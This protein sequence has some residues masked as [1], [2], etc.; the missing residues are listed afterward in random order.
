MV[1]MKCFIG[2]LRENLT[3]KNTKCTKARCGYGWD[4]ENDELKIG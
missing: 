1:G 2:E 3:T 4:I